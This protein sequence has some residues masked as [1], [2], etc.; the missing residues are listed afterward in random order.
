MDKLSGITGK[1]YQNKTVLN[2]VHAGEINF[3]S[4]YTLLN[5]EAIAP[6]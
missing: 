2:F 5:E 1:N 3:L 6:R 4:L